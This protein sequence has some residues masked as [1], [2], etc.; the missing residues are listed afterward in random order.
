MEAMRRRLEGG[1][2][3]SGEE[4]EEE[5]VG[6]NV[7]MARKSLMRTNSMGRMVRDT[8]QKSP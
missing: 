7:K 2:E 5:E 1:G 3:E 6:V 4:E 8:R